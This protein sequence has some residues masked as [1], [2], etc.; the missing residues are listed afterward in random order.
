MVLAPLAAVLFFGAGLEHSAGLLLLPPLLVYAGSRRGALFSQLHRAGDPSYGIYLLGCP[1]AQAVQGVWPDLPFV[2][3]LL[4]A[5]ALSAAA[6]YAS[7]HAVEAPALRLKT[8][9]P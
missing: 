6:G 5:M 2:P 3:S 9:I 4:L 1:I 8:L 7:W